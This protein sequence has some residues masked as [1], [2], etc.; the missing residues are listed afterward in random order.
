MGRVHENQV[1]EICEQLCGHVLEGRDE[2]RYVQ[3]ARARRWRCSFVAMCARSDIYSIG[4]KTLINDV[5]STVGHVVARRTTVPLL[6]GV[7]QD[8]NDDLRLECLDILGEL[9]KRFGRDT[10]SEHASLAPTLQAQVGSA[11]CV[12]LH[13]G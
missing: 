6:R 8:G 4:L 7:Q 12:L 5:P 11:V 9:L 10:E 13:P 3:R 1:A 2:L